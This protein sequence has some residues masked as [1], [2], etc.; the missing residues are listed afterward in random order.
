MCLPLTIYTKNV[1]NV[2]PMHIPPGTV[3]GWVVNMAWLSV[4]AQNL[5]SNCNPD[6]G[7]R[8]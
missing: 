5:M 7:G 3:D 2:Y 6:V 8:G 1:Y 4:P